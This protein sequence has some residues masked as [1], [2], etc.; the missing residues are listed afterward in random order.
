LRQDAQ[1]R[2]NLL[3]PIVELPSDITPGK[4]EA[5]AIVTV[6]GGRGFVVEGRRG[7][8]V[9][10]AA[11]CLPVFPPCA[12][13]SFDE[14]RTY[15]ALLGP[16]GEAPTVW[17]E[18]MFVDPIGDIAVLRSPDNQ[19]FFE[20]AEN[21]EAF[22]DAVTPLKPSTAGI[23]PDNPPVQA[24]MFSLDGRWFG[25][26]AEFRGLWPLWTSEETE[27][28]R[29]GMSGSPILASDGSVI[30]VVTAGCEAPTPQ[31]LFNLPVW[32]L[33]EIGLCSR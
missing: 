7:R 9:I 15:Q 14:E 13:I 31:L 16:L 27:P 26:K 3:P 17:A 11:H 33:R 20:Q 30:G 6:G 12:T 32:I 19:N 8:F 5:S 1:G 21:F 10:T 4:R 2:R 23:A 18:C 29:S 28:V 24:W 25:C 22:V